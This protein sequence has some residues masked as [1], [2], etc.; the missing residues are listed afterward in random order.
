MEFGRKIIKYRCNEM[1][2]KIKLNNQLSVHSWTKDTAEV[3]AIFLRTNYPGV[4]VQ[5]V[6]YKEIEE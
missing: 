2:Y 1:M 4:V 5:I 3:R 6:P